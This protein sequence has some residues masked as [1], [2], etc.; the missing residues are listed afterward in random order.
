[1]ARNPRIVIFGQDV[2]DASNVEALAAGRRQGR[3]VQGHARP[4]APVR[5][6]HASST[7]RSPRPTSS[8]ARSGMALRGL[9]PVVEIQFFDYIWP[10]FMQ[11]RDE[12]SMMRYRSGNHWSCPVVIR[13]PIGGY[14]RGGAPY[15]SQSAVAIFAHTPGLRIVLPSNAQDAAGLLRTAIRMRRPG[16]LL[17]AQA[18]VPADLQQG[19]VSRTGLHDPVRQGRRPA[20]RHRHRR[21]HLGRARAAVAARGAAGRASGHQ[22]RGHRP[23]DDH[24]VRLGDDRR[25]TRRRPAGSSSRTRISSRPASARRSPRAS[26]RIC[27]NTSTPRSRASRRSTA[28][29]PTRRTSRT[30]SC[31]ARPTC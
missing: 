22:R 17:R 5:R 14:L 31:R 23:A 27:S 1:M 28:R 10:A 21:L 15:H 20:R 4:A 7:R 30:P 6:A 11:I 13:V 3:R 12:L 19:R 24:P 8:G 2:A 26:R 16:A 9:K 18:P 29:S 25:P